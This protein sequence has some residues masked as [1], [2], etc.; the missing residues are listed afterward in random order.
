MRVYL[1]YNATT[2][3]DN[4]VVEAMVPYFSQNFGNAG[5]IHSE[6]QRAR[7]AVDA[8]RDSVAALMGRRPAR[9]FSRAA[10]PKRTTWRSLECWGAERREGGGASE[11]AA[12]M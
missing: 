9:S 3:V 12:S 6:G 1:D 10:G 5:S 11:G 2:P 4:A 8:A 7:A